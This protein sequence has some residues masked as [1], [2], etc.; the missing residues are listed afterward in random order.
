MHVQGCVLLWT[1]MQRERML[2]CI[3]VRVYV[4]VCESVLG[5]ACG[6]SMLVCTLVCACVRGC[7]CVRE[8]VLVWTCM[9]RERA[10][11]H[12]CL[13]VCMCACMHVCARVGMCL[14]I[15]RKFCMLV[16]AAAVGSA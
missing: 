4:F 14:F 15:A 11:M 6:V 12:S 13:C 16:A 1:C 10:C 8:H 7:V 3:L 9:Q 5:H 2:V